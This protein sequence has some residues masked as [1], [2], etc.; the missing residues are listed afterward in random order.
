MPIVGR[1]PNGLP[2]RLCSHSPCRLQGES[3]G[4]HLWSC[5]TCGLV[6]VPGDEHVTVERE[7][8]RYALH[9]NTPD[10]EGYVSY[11]EG[12]A[13]LLG[14]VPLEKPVV[15]D[16][17][18]GEHAVLVDV[19]RRRGVDCSGYDPL[20]GVGT[21]VTGKRF[22]VIIACEVVEHLRDLAAEAALLGRMLAPGGYLVIRTQYAP[23]AVEDLL[24][25]WYVSDVT[26]VNFFGT[27]SLAWLARAMGLA[28][29][30]DNGRDTCVLG[31]NSG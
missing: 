3:G 31:P 27:K 10:N 9:D 24:S 6:F 29:H 19:L 28:V 16:F 12:V 26:H 2:C 14:M 13:D 18:C 20:C 1:E 22:D 23:S 7:R 15:L 11:M 8:E 25:W 30:C 17:G 5:P 21:D 4:R